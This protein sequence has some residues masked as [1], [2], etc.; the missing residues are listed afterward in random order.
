MKSIILL[1]F[2]YF[3]CFLAK[4][5]SDKTLITNINFDNSLFGEKEIVL[6]KVYYDY[7]EMT[8]YALDSSSYMKLPNGIELYNNFSLCF[9]IKYSNTKEKQTLFYQSNID[10]SNNINRL[11]HIGM[12]N[13]KVFLVLL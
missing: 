7:S 10:T 9:R 6:S 11:F 8:T 1:S 2:L 13:K 3:I 12:R 5:Q 4:G